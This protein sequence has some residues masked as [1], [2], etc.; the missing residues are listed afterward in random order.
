MFSERTLTF[1]RLLT[2]FRRGA[3][4]DCFDLI[5]EILE[6]RIVLIFL[7]HWS[8]RM[9]QSPCASVTPTETIHRLPMKSG[10]TA[11]GSVPSIMNRLAV[12]R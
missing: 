4:Q 2:P 3:I 8:A 10:L 12:S 11:P 9:C 7:L 1:D 6:E 5:S